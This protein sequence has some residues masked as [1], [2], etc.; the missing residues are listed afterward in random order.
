MLLRG[1]LIAYTAV[2]SPSLWEIQFPEVRVCEVYAYR[3]AGLIDP[4][5]AVRWTQIV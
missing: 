2:G 3:I 4:F 5:L 1:A